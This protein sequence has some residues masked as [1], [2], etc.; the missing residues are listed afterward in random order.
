MI[1]LQKSANLNNDVLINLKPNNQ[2]SSKNPK[3]YQPYRTQPVHSNNKLAY[4]S[5]QNEDSD[6]D[7]NDQ[8][9][10][11]QLQDS[12]QSKPNDDRSNVSLSTISNDDDQNSKDPD[13]S[14]KNAE[15]G[16]PISKCCLLI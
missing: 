10:P 9:D 8:S 13:S 3:K 15:E 4:K 1:S 12:D 6:S 7:D 5:H 2:S 14:Q 11:F 16:E